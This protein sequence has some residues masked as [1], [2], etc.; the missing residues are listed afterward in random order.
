MNKGPGSLLLDGG[1]GVHQDLGQHTQH[2]CINGQLDLVI[3]S[4]D[5]VPHSAER[6]SLWKNKARSIT[7]YCKLIKVEGNNHT[8]I[9]ALPN[10]SY[11]ILMALWKP[12]NNDYIHDSY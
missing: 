10:I 9:C 12:V 5:D 8:K 11:V 7:K 3:H 6:G 1:L 2:T 4:R